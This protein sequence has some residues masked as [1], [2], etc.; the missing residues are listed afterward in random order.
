MKIVNVLIDYDNVKSI[1]EKSIQDVNTN[2]SL[3]IRKLSDRIHG[4]IVD[5]EEIACRLYGGWIT[6]DRSYTD[7]ASWLLSQVP[8]FRGRAGPLRVRVTLSLN[9]IC[10]SDIHLVGTYRDGGQKMVDGMISTDLIHLSGDMTQSLVLVSDDDDFVPGII[11]G[12]MMR[13]KR[14]PIYIL[15]KTKKIGSAPNDIFLESANAILAEY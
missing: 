10:R 8:R 7:R 4:L 5:S 3:I 12:G 13:A 1:E 14:Q 2:L 11:A 6:L 15:R 9:L